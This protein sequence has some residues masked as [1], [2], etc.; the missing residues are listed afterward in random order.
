M[1]FY[2][3]DNKV[4]TELHFSAGSFKKQLHSFKRRPP[5][6]LKKSKLKV[7]SSYMPKTIVYQNWITNLLI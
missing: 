3:Y 7:N 4:S 2:Q 5:D 1:I 6:F